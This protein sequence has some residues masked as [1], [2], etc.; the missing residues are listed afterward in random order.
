MEEVFYFFCY[1]YGCVGVLL[2][3]NEFIEYVVWIVVRYFLKMIEYGEFVIGYI[4]V[5]L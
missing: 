3:V 2:S 4:Y 5:F 1:V